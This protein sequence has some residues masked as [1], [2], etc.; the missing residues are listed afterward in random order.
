MFIFVFF[1]ENLKKTFL[2]NAVLPLVTVK[3]IGDRQGN[4]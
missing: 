1:R 4:W 2:G 3:V